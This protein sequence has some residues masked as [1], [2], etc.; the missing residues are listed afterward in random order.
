MA[1]N[2]GIAKYVLTPLM[3]YARNFHKKHCFL[4]V[5]LKG[6]IYNIIIKN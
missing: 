4:L 3:S 5:C 1:D 6:T 2:F